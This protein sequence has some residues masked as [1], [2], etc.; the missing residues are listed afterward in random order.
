MKTPCI[1]ASVALAT[2]SLMAAEP[3]GHWT[4]GWIENDLFNRSD[5]HYT[6][7]TKG[8]WLA[9]EHRSGDDV[10]S[11]RWAGV[12]PDLGQQREFVRWGVSLG[13]NIYTPSDIRVAALI[14]EE[15][16]YAGYLYTTFH[17]QSRGQTR[18]GTP[19]LDTWSMDLGIVGPDAGGEDAQNT[20]HR[21][22]N[23]GEAMGWANQLK[24][25]PAIN[26]RYARVARFSVGTPGGWESQ[27]LP[28]WGLTVGSVFTHAAGGGQVRMG[29]NLPEDFG[30]R[31]IDDLYPGNGGRARSEENRFSVYVFG[32][33]EGRVV[34][35]NMLLDGNLYHDSHSVDKRVLVGEI[36]G[37]VA[38]AYGPVEFSFTEL[39]R[40]K[41]YE[42]QK[43]IDT[44]ASVALGVRW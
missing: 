17:L 38:L 15:R 30:R 31:G 27:L 6:H 20:V 1:A 2:A 43:V 14:P 41:E 26:L 19:V 22:R 39:A 5:R 7:G 25:E 42:G 8:T 28:H 11:V 13:Q 3:L 16:P 23:F 40:S 9:R 33:V 29:W 24:N 35:W 32:G 34:G 18:G 10:W 36:R 37:G 12:L 4:A 21:L 44:F